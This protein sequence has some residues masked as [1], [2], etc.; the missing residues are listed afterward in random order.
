MQRSLLKS[1]SSMFR[2]FAQ[3]C[4][5]TLTPVKSRHR[6]TL[7]FSSQW[8]PWPKRKCKS[9]RQPQL[10]SSRTSAI[11][12]R[13]FFFLKSGYLISFM[14][15]LTLECIIFLYSR[16]ICRWGRKSLAICCFVAF[17]NLF[18]ANSPSQKKHKMTALFRVCK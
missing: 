10:P 17:L 1:C 9:N 5:P 16:H 7:L 12:S 15:G 13:C 2:I 11:L 18:C 14:S 4:W 3:C 6:A 8:W